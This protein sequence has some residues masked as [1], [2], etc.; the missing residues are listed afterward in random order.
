MAAASWGTML[1]SAK[2]EGLGNTSALHPRVGK[3][4]CWGF[5]HNN[6][7]SSEFKLCF[8]GSEKSSGLFRIPLTGNGATFKPVL[9]IQPEG[10]QVGCQQSRA[11]TLLFLEVLLISSSCC[12]HHWLGSK[13]TLLCLLK[14]VTAGRYWDYFFPP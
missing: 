9:A 6:N 8:C 7:K 13:Y 3:R 5:F 11:E 1:C 4:L 10:H 14:R 2:G 12:L